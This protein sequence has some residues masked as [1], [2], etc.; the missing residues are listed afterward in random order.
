[1]RF[2][3]AK[4]LFIHAKKAAGMSP[5]TIR[6]YESS[7]KNFCLFAVNKGVYSA[8]DVSPR[9]IEEYLIF[10]RR[11]GKNSPL[12]VF[13]SYRDMR[14]WFRWLK[15]K[16]YMPECPIDEVD[17]PRKGRQETRVFTVKEIGIIFSS[18]NKKSFFGYR[19]FCICKT[20]LGTGLRRA[21]LVNLKDEDMVG[22]MFRVIGKGNKY[23]AVPIPNEL[24]SILGHYI[25]MRNELYP[26]AKY[27]FVNATGKGLGKEGLSM[28]MRRVKERTGIQGERVSCHTFRHTFATMFL[29]NGGSIAYL[30]KILGHSSIS[31]TEKYLHLQTSG[32][33]H[34]HA[35]YN[36][37]DNKDWM[38]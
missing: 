34:E 17:A 28:V 29:E 16:N 20:L 15:K 35:M 32:I 31:T 11:G 7:I 36:P 19:D 12:T 14:T 13:D 2:R 37:L 9:L 33:R 27:L 38:I 30:Q 26:D 21:E 5:E 25:S 23:R 24:S 3:D 10:K 22:N 18:F 1:M 4:D 6:D 8:E